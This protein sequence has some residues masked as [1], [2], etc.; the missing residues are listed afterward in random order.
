MRRVLAALALFAAGG[1]MS[2]PVA[3]TQDPLEWL[4]RIATAGQGLSYVGTF[5]YQSGGEFETSRIVHRVDQQGAHER[6]EVLDGSPREVIRSNGVVRCVLPDQ[7]MVIVDEASGR[8]AFPARLPTAYAT[9]VE[10]YDVSMGGQ[11]RVAG[12]DVQVIN[13]APRDALR[14]GHTLWADLETG[15]LLK[16]RMVDERGEVVEQFTFA[17][18]HVGGE[19][20]MDAL[21][22]RYEMSEAWREINARGTPVSAGEGGWALL[23]PVQGYALKSM[24]MRQLGREHGEV[25]HMVFTDG[26]ATVSVFVEP[27][28]PTGEREGIG[29]LASGPINIYKRKLGDHLITALGEVPQRAV[30]LIG[31]GISPVTQ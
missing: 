21:Q 22:P 16:A 31:D 24:V 11:A 26:L 19:I 2:L 15:L 1:L 6:L 9:V 18:V 23:T 7:K 10:N 5:T 8:R 17:D 13:L 25:L 29:A 28:D 12:K 4:G 20:G 30:Q 27:A 3:A 14:Y